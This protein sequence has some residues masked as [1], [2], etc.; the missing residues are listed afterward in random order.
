[1][2]N[3]I[4]EGKLQSK[5]ELKEDSIINVDIKKDASACLYF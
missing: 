4:I 2:S 1:M 5:I 3:Y